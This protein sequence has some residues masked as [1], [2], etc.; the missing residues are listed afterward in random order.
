MSELNE[1]KSPHFQQGLILKR[2]KQF[3]YVEVEGQTHLCRIKGNLFEESHYENK[4]A[5]GD[6]V[7]VDLEAAQ[8]AG[9]IYEILPRKSKLSRSL[10]DTELEQVLV[11]NADYLL[12]VASVGKPAFRGGVVER[13]FIA[14]QRGNLHPILILNKI[15]LAEEEEIAPIQELYQSLGYQVFLTSATHNL[16][17]DPVKEILANRI[18]IFAGHSGVGK[19]SLVKALFP[20]WDLRVEDV[21]KKWGRGRHT[22]TLAV[23]YPLPGKTG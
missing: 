17:L 10:R 8:D 1:K 6:W 14:A 11:S 3:N 19:S 23:M 16:G 13:F 5:V 2:M 7:K 12:I 20:E 22:T 18:S 15:D 21:D 4:I 9:L